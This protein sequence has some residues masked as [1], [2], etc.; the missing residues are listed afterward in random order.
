MFIYF[1]PS[2]FQNV[3]LLTM[4]PQE[5]YIETVVTCEGDFYDPEFHAQL[6][7]LKQRLQDLIVTG[8]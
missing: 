4:G 2:L 5:D 7:D 1:T 3:K 8:L 6:L